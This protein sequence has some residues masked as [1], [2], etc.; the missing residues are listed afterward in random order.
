MRVESPKLN[1][2]SGE[3]YHQQM[4]RERE[5]PGPFY[6]PPVASLIT[7]GGRLLLALAEKC[8]ADAG[9]THLFCDTDS[10]CIVAN[11][12]GGFSRGGTCPDLGYVEGADPR[13]F[14]PVPCLSH[15]RVIDISKRFASLNPYS[16]GGTI[17][18]VEDVNYQDSDPS[19]P[20]RDLHGYAI[21]AKRYCLFEGKHARKIIDAKAHAIGYLMNPIRRK[22]DEDGDQFAA[23]FWRKVLQNEGIA[24]KAD[25]PTG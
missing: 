14:A 23:A 15:D 25:E 18:K 4:I 22:R 10:L 9:G 16:F 20:F 7:A 19:Q 12:K 24:L 17:L 1:V 6:F 2:H 13:E 21:S 3:H 8:V 11:E 5:V